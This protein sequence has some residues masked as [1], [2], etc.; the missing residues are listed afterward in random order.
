MWV[1]ITLAVLVELVP[2]RLRTSA[3]AVYLF[4]ISNV[5]GNMPLLVPVLM[6]AFDHS[7]FHGGHSLRGG[8]IAAV[9]NLGV[10]RAF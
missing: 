10:I 6:T 4:I 3:V 8:S 9:F 7:G 5:G 1:A 2:R